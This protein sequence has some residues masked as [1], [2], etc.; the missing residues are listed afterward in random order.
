MDIN[1]STQSLLKLVYHKCVICRRKRTRVWLANRHKLAKLYVLTAF[2]Y[3]QLAFFS[4]S[5]SSPLSPGSFVHW[6]LQV[7]RWVI[8]LTDCRHGLKILRRNTL[9]ETLECWFHHQEISCMFS[10]SIRYTVSY[11]D[12]P[13]SWCSYGLTQHYPWSA[14]ITPRLWLRIQDTPA[15]HTNGV[16][17]VCHVW[18]PLPYDIDHIDSSHNQKR[19]ES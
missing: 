8:R 11:R 3:H 14:I 17:S 13:F 4:F 1:K 15:L 7:T 12:L 2:P 6:Y 10:F 18:K 9:Q 5:L 16:A 19:L